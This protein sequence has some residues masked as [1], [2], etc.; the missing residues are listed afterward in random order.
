M[1]RHPLLS[2]TPMPSLM[3]SLRTRLSFSALGISGWLM[4]NC[5]A[6]ATAIVLNIRSAR[7]LITILR[8]VST[9]TASWHS[10]CVGGR[11]RSSTSSMETFFCR[12][13]LRTTVVALLAASRSPAS[14]VSSGG[15][16]TSDTAMLLT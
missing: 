2:A 5:R 10:S 15:S 3:P 1:M 8:E 12:S 11:S 7:T 4:M 6:L 9:A 16:A 13:K 14:Q